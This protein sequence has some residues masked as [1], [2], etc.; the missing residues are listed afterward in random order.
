MS[1]ADESQFT[2]PNPEAAAIAGLV[3]LINRAN[4]Q[5]EQPGGEA[6]PQ[7]DYLD[8]MTV[9]E[10]SKLLRISRNVAYELVKEPGFPSLQVGR[11][12]RVPRAG[13][14]LWVR[15][16]IDREMPTDRNAYRRSA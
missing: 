16:N 7:S 13:L 9:H 12:I 4:F 8:L 11:G 2:Y 14:E 3:A 5:P 6:G 15:A 10:V 1:A